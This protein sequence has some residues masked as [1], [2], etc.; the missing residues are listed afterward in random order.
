MP[1]SNKLQM[2]DL[3]PLYLAAQACNRMPVNSKTIPLPAESLFVC[4][5][6]LHSGKD[7]FRTHKQTG[8]AW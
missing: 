6:N 4:L 7:Y 1:E 3:C 5:Q 2:P 8:I